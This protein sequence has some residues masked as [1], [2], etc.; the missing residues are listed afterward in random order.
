MRSERNQIMVA[1]Y[2]NEAEV[3]AALKRAKTP[4]EVEK[5]AKDLEQRMA[6]SHWIQKALRRLYTLL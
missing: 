1:Y 5:I 6:P 3:D 4:L 2:A